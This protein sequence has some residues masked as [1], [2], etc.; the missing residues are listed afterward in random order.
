MSILGGERMKK[1]KSR[2]PLLAAIAVLGVVGLVVIS[3]AASVL[4]YRQFASDE[5]GAIGVTLDGLQLDQD[6]EDAGQGVLVLR[7]EPGSPAEQAGLSAGS[8]ILSVNG[9]PVN[10]PQ[11]LKDRIGE[12]EVGDSVTLTVEDGDETK[13]VAVTLG[14]SGPYL[15]VNVGPAPR[16]TGWAR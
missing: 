8:V 11:E 1:Q 13:D 6:Q 3:A 9:R 15:G 4:A 7:V 5:K 10:S 14:D 2:W 16:S 12:Y